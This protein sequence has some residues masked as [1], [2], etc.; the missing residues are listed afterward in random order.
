MHCSPNVSPHRNDS[1]STRSK[2]RTNSTILPPFHS[3]TL[4]F[5]HPSILP[6][7]HSSILPPA[8]RKD[9]SLEDWKVGRMDGWLFCSLDAA[10][11]AWEGRAWTPLSSHAWPIGFVRRA[12]SS[13]LP[14]RESPPSRAFRIFA[15]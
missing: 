14:V 12:R 15:G 2:I 4:P 11:G 5:F 9:G 1:A 10:R 13:C 8:S 3:S 7:F 6:P